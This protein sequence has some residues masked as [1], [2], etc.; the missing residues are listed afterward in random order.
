[1]NKQEAIAYLERSIHW[2]LSCNGT[3]LFG[4]WHGLFLVGDTDPQALMAL[5]EDAEFTERVDVPFAWRIETSDT[6]IRLIHNRVHISLSA[7]QNGKINFTP[8]LFTR[9]FP[10]SSLEGF[11]QTHQVM[12]QIDP[13]VECLCVEMEKVCAE[14]TAN[15][16]QQQNSRQQAEQ[17]F[18][19]ALPTLRLRG[20]KLTKEL[21]RVY[22][23]WTL[24]QQAVCP[25]DY[26][27]MQTLQE[28]GLVNEVNW[29]S[30]VPSQKVIDAVK[31][32]P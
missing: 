28:R 24:H 27:T 14:L 22:L 17:A 6:S 19:Q 23:N 15:L 10:S 26:K 3:N 5:P 20:S 12:Q 7:T 32:V 2:T 31:A 30:Y 18:I 11:K 16:K 25:M 8:M 1:M 29:R 9:P 13:L 4:Y 21:M